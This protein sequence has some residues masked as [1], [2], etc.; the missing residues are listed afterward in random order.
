V[1]DVQIGGC[2]RSGLFLNQGPALLYAE[3]H[4]FFNHVCTAHTSYSPLTPCIIK[5]PSMGRTSLKITPCTV[6]TES[7]CMDT[8]KQ[9]TKSYGLI[10]G[11]GLD[12]CLYFGFISRNTPISNFSLDMF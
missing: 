12:S 1:H 4:V 2:N 11:V 6:H 3:R 7:C 10:T 8:W 5:V 9:S